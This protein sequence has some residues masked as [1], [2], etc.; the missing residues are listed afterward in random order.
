MESLRWRLADHPGPQEPLFAE[1]DAAPGRRPLP[2][3]EYL[4]VRARRVISEVPEG[5]R[6]PFR[7]TLNAYRGCAHACMYCYA[8]PTH[9]FLGLGATADFERRIV[10]KINA[11]ERL[12][13]ELAETRVALGT[14][15]H[16]RARPARPAAAQLALAVLPMSGGR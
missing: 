10:V 7:F 2:G 14:D 12:R 15:V 3:V 1:G 16:G 6:L 8:R 11:V 13:A 5:A 4:H 9:G